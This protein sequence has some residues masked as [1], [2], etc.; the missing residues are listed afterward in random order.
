MRN[1][2]EKGF[3]LV[4]L[5]VVMG[6][7]AVLIMIAIAGLGF[8][9]RR[10]RNTA[11]QSAVSNLDKALAAYYTDHQEYPSAADMEY[12]VESSLVDYLEGSWDG[13]SGG[14]EYCY[15]TNADNL[16]YLVCCSQEALTGN[17]DYFCKGPGI[18][19]DGFPDTKTPAAPPTGATC[20]KW[21]GEGGWSGSSFK[22][23]EK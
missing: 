6:I 18:G 4:E 2:K 15:K 14:S 23:K 1:R 19:S 21:D 5:L 13:G 3:S 7:M 9:M 8:A 22:G 16:T 12:L 17:G 11:R 20:D 10:S